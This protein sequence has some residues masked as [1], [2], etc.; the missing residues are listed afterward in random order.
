MKNPNMD[1]M[2]SPSLEFSS[3]VTREK[4]DASIIITDHSN[5]DYEKIYNKSKLII[6]TRNVFKNKTGSHVKRLGQ[7]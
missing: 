7:G 5:V 4:F 2:S 3:V 1:S 6:D